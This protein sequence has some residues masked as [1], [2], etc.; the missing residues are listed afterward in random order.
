MSENEKKKQMSAGRQKILTEIRRWTYKTN[1]TKRLPRSARFGRGLQLLGWGPECRNARG[2]GGG[3][4]N[5]MW[6]FCGG[7]NAGNVVT[8][9]GGKDKTAFFPGQ[10]KTKTVRET[11]IAMNQ[12]RKRDQQFSESGG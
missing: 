8:T 2:T 7:I 6:G 1:L 4:L 12:G 5:W 3:W 11:N 10:K 9:R